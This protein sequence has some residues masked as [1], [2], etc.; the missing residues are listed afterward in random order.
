MNITKGDVLE[1]R[2]R[3]K[4]TEC[5][6]GRLCGCYVNSGKQVVLKFSE[7][8]SELEEDEFYKYLEIAKK[9]LSG[10]L[11]GNLLELEF[12]RTEQAAER[13]KYLLMLKGSKLANEELLD[14]LYE[15]VIAEYAY[16]GNYL[17]LV[18][19]DVY[20]VPAKA[21]SGEEQEESE[22]IYEYLLCAVCP[23]D[24]AKPALGYCEEENRIGA[25][26]RDWVVGKPDLGFVYPAFSGRSSDVNAVMYYVRTGRSSH[27]ELVENVLG[28]VS[29]RTA[30]EDKQAFQS[31]VKSAFGEDTEQAD[32]AFFQ[33]QKT[34]SA[35]VA[36]REEDPSLPPVS[37]TAEAMADLAEEAEVSDAVR[38]QLGKTYAQ[39]FGD[40]P[41]AAHN[42]LD[43]RLVEEGT[44]R[45]HTAALEQK[46][47]VLQQELAQQAADRVE[48]EGD[49]PP[50]EDTAAG[51]IEL[52]MPEERAARIR[53]ERIGGQRCLLIP[54][55]EG[56]SAQI[57]GRETTL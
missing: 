37:L 8:F 55:E 30:A 10:T 1:L 42:V 46:V 21:T 24:L 45:A 26:E 35:M 31:V 16:P 9:T 32:A 47:A 56:E 54:L 50:W 53:A 40:V 38:E 44:A 25:R 36:E 19:H 57:N 2:R 28:C 20:D 41:P 18:Y 39:V 7:P 52:R 4:K 11:G 27:P 34:I 6:F 33:M 15:Q 29:Q 5:T 12:A 14:R 48:A 51:R 17:I 49:I 23:V 13:Q 43:S 3:L 22:E